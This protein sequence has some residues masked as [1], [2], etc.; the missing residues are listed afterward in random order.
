[1]ICA[2]D[3]WYVEQ[4]RQATA[5]VKKTSFMYTLHSIAIIPYYW[6]R[7]TSYINE[8]IHNL[9]CKV[10]W[11]YHYSKW[12]AQYYYLW[13]RVLVKVFSFIHIQLS[14]LLNIMFHALMGRFHLELFYL[15][16]H[17]RPTHKL[18]FLSC[19]PFVVNATFSTGL[20]VSSISW[21][22]PGNVEN[23]ALTT[24]DVQERKHNLWIGRRWKNRQ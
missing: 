21:P 19:R 13:R 16:F 5:T 18:W 23:V 15:F 17:R 7:G 2:S 11:N 14:M 9:I 4:S 12:R 24:K 22:K 6:L 1:M 8:F 10:L 3:K 20:V